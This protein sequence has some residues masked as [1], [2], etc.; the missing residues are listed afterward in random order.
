MGVKNISDLVLKEI[1]DICETKNPTEEQI[2]NYKMTERKIYEKFDDL[3]EDELNRKRNKNVY[4]KNN[5]MSN[6]I[7][8]CR[9]KKKRGIRAI[10]GFRV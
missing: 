6:I 10:E 7:K 1:C 5:V 4:A 2:K 8:C 9:G 3:S